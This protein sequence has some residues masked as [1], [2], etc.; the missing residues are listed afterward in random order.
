MRRIPVGNG[1]IVCLSVLLTCLAEQSNAQNYVYDTG[2][3]TYGVSFPVPNGFINV[4]NGNVHLEIPLGTFTQRGNLPSLTIKLVYDSRIW[5]INQN[6]STYSWQPNNIYN[7]MAGWRLSIGAGAYSYQSSTIPCTTQFQ[8]F[9]FVDN[10]GTPHVFPFKTIEY[11]S[12]CSG[13][14]T[15]TASGYATDSSGYY[16]VVTNYTNITIYDSN[17]VR[18]YHYDG[19]VPNIGE[20]DA[21][22]NTITYS[23]T[24]SNPTITDTVSRS[25]VTVTATGNTIQYGILTTGGGRNTVTVTTEPLSVNTAFGEQ[26]V[27]EF[28]GTLTGIKSIGLPDGSS[29]QFT[30]DA[31]QSFPGQYGELTGM[32]MPLA[33]QIDSDVVF[34]WSSFFDSYQ[35]V[36]RWI[37]TYTGPG[38]YTTFAPK[39]LS[40]CTTSGS[41][42]VGCQ[43]QMTLTRASND[44]TVYT[45][46]LNNGAWDTQTDFYSGSVTSGAKKL[47]TVTGYNFTNSCDPAICQGAQWVTASS[48]TVTLD[49]VGQTAKTSYTYAQPW[50]GKPSQVQQWDYIAGTPSG[51]PARETDFTYGYTVNGAALLT[52]ESTYFKGV[53]FGQTVFN[54]DQNTP[55]ATSGLPQHLA[56][57]GPRGN[58]TSVT[59]GLSGGPQATS[60]FAYDDAGMQLS[61]TDPNQG[62]TVYAYMCNDTYSSQISYP[63]TSGISH[64][65]KSSEDCNSGSVLSFTDQNS[66]VTTYGY[67]NLG[68]PSSVLYPDG[69]QTSYSYPSPAQSVITK[70]VD[71]ST[72]SVQTSTLDEF[73]RQSQISQ[74][75]PAGSDVV[76][77]SYDSN[78][79]LHCITNPQR[80][81]PSPTDGQTCYQY[82][83]L[84]RPTQVTQPDQKT[85]QVSYSG[86]Q[87]TVTDENGH[88]R[89]YQ[90][91]AF[92][93][94]TA[95]WE[96]DSSGAL[97]WET[98]Y[99]YDGAGTLTK[100]T[101]NGS[102]AG[103]ARVRTFSFD[104][105]GR[106]ISENSP[107]A[108]T[109]TYGYLRNNALC[110]GDL[111]LPCSKTDARNV[112][113][114]FTYDALNRITGKTSS[115]GSITYSYYYDQPGH[116]DS[117]GQITHISNNINAAFDPTYDAM[118]RVISQSYC[119]PSD[120]SYGIRVQASYDLAG[121]LSSLTYPDGR[122]VSYSYDSAQHMTGVKYA[123]WNGQ[124]VNT[125]Y[126]NSATTSFAPPGQMTSGTLGNGVQVAASFGPRQ[127]IASLQYK[128]SSQTLWS[129][130]FTWAAN[131]QNLVQLVDTTSSPQ[132][133]NYSYDPDNRLISATGGGQT[134]VSPAT[135]GTGNVTVSGA[136]KSTLYMPPGCRLHSC[137]QT[138]YD[139]GT[140]KIT[141]NNYVASASYGQGST[142]SAIASS[143]VAQ[144]NS[145]SSYPVSA[146]LSGSTIY[147]AAK[148]TG[149]ITN[150]SLST[151]STWDTQDFSSSSFSASKSGSTLTGGADA[152]YNGAAILNEAYNPD[153]WGNLQQSGNFSFIQSFGNNNQVSTAG[154]GYDQAG[155]VINDGIGNSYTFDGEGKLSA[156]S[157][158]SYVY[159]ASGLRVEKISGGT[160]T[161]YIY[162]NNKAIALLNPSA[163]A[164]TDLIFAGDTP[165]AEVAGNQTAS[166]IYRLADHLGSVVVETDGFGNAIGSNLYAPY[167]Q[168]LASSISD[169]FAFTGLEHDNENG[170][171]HALARNYLLA[172]S[173]WINPDPDDF[174]YDLMN[175]Q[176]FNRYAYV[177]GNPLGYT[178]ATGL[179]GEG[180]FGAG[181][182]IG[183]CVGV[184]MSEGGN[185]F[186][187]LGCAA[188]LLKD[189]FGLFGG[190]P[191]FHG[192]LSPRPRT[193]SPWDGNLGESLGIPVNGPP[194]NMGG[195]QGALGMP[196]AGC[197]FGACGNGSTFTAGA[198]TAPLTWCGEHPTVCAAGADLAAF[199]RAVPAVAASVLLLRMEGDRT[200]P[201]AAYLQQNCQPGRNVQEPATGRAYKGGISIEQEYVCTSGV[202][203][204]HWIQVGSK[205]VHGPHVRPGPPKGGDSL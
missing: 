107:E 75:D 40:Q 81:T 140:V 82:D 45:L 123:S 106:L 1:L 163:G 56:V 27:Q 28:T 11:L 60:S 55:T 66:R 125:P 108:G 62:T 93:D 180:G 110:A 3:P 131:A 52:S 76:T 155:D 132:T 29:Y 12:G 154:Y 102:N 6:L 150:Y 160:T 50:I 199:A 89:R 33:P 67:D 173:R 141:V 118:G 167:G 30:Y 204:V 25:P 135:S 104:G 144:I 77:H 164:W 51:T 187:D 22:G 5:R 23:G 182:A 175:P 103:A 119:I 58:L 70:V 153:A 14:G 80:S 158:S 169:A 78:G 179:D 203:T 161:E 68:R 43:E 19:T 9:A 188:S 85:L 84:D 101:Q 177:N 159:D 42:T 10:H 195:L 47:T 157:G 200:F 92:H 99:Q 205:I 166:P 146:T 138:I 113:I 86:D 46:T 105:L 126:L 72:S 31:N 21:N 65:T 121:D 196:S 57:A 117:V 2:S 133:Y 114:Q 191:T 145:N 26:G 124:T 186:A 54:Y 32:N 53:L 120:C 20:E 79:R 165:L 17:G 176:S 128:T 147:L 4:A 94:L 136:E 127:T 83:F 44:A 109:T 63:S 16:A 170:S 181:G 35:N 64:I 202:Y 139:N 15:T 116:G 24:E 148:A 100:I 134:L 34:A 143:L 149:A 73:G 172:P 130:Q 61:S 171:Y 122:V 37:T 36:N 87:A 185:P 112:T 198:A 111:S 49:D 95:T 8:H 174:S 183:G 90:Y 97:N 59:K 197:E 152:V 193:G 115:D 137:A 74:S 178:D 190:G 162:F 39:V 142:A 129:K 156:S 192:S 7:S 201:D 88:L 91:D 194:F 96:P 13:T 184:A 98:D 48:S 38:G 71:G 168:L 151:S 41:T 18:V 189:L 69:G